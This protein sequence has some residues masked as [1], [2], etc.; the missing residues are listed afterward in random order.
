MSCMLYLKGVEEEVF[1]EP[2]HRGQGTRNTGLKKDLPP[3]PVTEA[4]TEA[5]LKKGASFKAAYG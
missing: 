1:L 5:F 3:K 2:S 4:G